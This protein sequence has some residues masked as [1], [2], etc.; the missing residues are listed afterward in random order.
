[1]RGWEGPLAVSGAVSIEAL[2]EM[3]ATMGVRSTVDFAGPSLRYLLASSAS[4]QPACMSGDPF[5][6]PF[7]FDFDFLF[8]ASFSHVQPKYCSFATAALSSSSRC[9]RSKIDRTL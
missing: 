4:R 2:A 5:H 6:F 7:T 8:P 1:M 9:S 3:G